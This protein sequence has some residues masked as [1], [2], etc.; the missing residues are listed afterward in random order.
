[1][2]VLKVNH[3]DAPG[4]EA[5]HRRKMRGPRGAPVQGTTSMRNQKMAALAR[6]LESTIAGMPVLDQTGLTDNYDMEFS[7]ISRDAAGPEICGVAGRG[8]R[9]CWNNW[10]WISFRR[11]RRSKCWWSRR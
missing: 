9:S 1:M 7:T 2:L 5:G 6:R 3:A 10:G 8:R 4:L 11:T